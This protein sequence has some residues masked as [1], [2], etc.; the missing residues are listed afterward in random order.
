V[1]EPC[2]GQRN[3]HWS[4]NTSGEYVLAYHGLCLTD[5]SGSTTNG[6]QVQ[7]QNCVNAADQHWSV[8]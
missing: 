8:P 5:P 4:R 6:T 1:I 3:Q 7:V 2:N